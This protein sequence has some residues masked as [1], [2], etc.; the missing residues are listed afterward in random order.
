MKTHSA[1]SKSRTDYWVL[2][3]YSD[4]NIE[5]A[6]YICVGEIDTNRY[7]NIFEKPNLN[8]CTGI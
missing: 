1:M 4:Q 3:Q 7:L 6:E 8:T 2:L 5:L